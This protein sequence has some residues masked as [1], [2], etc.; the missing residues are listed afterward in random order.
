MLVVAAD[1]KKEQARCIL[2]DV[3]VAAFKLGVLGSVEIV[4]A[5]AGV[6]ADY[7]DVPLILDTVLASG[8]GDE[9]ADEDRREAMKEL[10]IP[11]STIIS[12]NIHELRRLAREEDS[13][14]DSYDNAVL[15]F[16]FK[17]KTAY[18]MPK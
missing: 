9:L 7:P 14:D 3:P 15:V 11:Q 4:A 5:V 16:F 12:P 10:L 13:D 2:E 1:L 8:R 6:I 18:E 17:Q